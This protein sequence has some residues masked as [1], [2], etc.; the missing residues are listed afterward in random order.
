MVSLIK[1]RTK[2]EGFREEGAD[3]HKPSD[4]KNDENEIGQAGVMYRRRKKCIQSFGTEI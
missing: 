4:D 1:R 3:K 2:A